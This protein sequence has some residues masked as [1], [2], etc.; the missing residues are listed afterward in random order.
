MSLKRRFF[1]EKIFTQLKTISDI[2]ISDMKNNLT[3][4]INKEKDLYIT[5]IINK[6]INSS[7]FSK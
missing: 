5:C 6:K 2:D 7:P 3:E 1:K 4:T